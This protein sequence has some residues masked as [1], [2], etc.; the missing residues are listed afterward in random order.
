MNTIWKLVLIDSMGVMKAELVDDAWLIGNAYSL[1]YGEDV[2][3]PK[4]TFGK[5]L[6]LERVI[7]AEIEED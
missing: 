3:L 1:F 6:K 4:G 2:Y 7:D 5:V